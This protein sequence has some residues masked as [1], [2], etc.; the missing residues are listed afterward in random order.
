MTVWWNVCSWIQEDSSAD[1]SYLYKI[2]C[3][4]VQSSCLKLCWSWRV[5]KFPINLSTFMQALI[6]GTLPS[7][8]SLQKPSL[9]L[10]SSSCS[11]LVSCHRISA[12]RQRYTH[13]SLASSTAHS[14][15]CQSVSPFTGVSL[16][17]PPLFSE[18]HMTALFSCRFWCIVPC[19]ALENEQTGALLLGLNSWEPWTLTQSDIHIR[20]RGVAQFLPLSHLPSGPQLSS[21]TL[22]EPPHHVFFR[23][24][25][26][27]L[28][29]EDAVIH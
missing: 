17:L 5:G 19:L 22:T 28:T 6:A 16:L 18:L 27:F 15:Q 26:G 10:A 24:Y 8:Y 29:T 9:Q 4:S 1:S 2:Y 25:A 23:I 3:T 11:Q 7:N 21:K 14:G 12:P 13:S 20:S